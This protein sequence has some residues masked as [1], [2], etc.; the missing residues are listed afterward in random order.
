M[1]LVKTVNVFDLGSPSNPF[2]LLLVSMC[3]QFVP[4]LEHS[5]LNERKQ[6]VQIEYASRRTFLS[7][8]SNFIHEFDVLFENHSVYVLSSKTFFGEPY[9]VGETSTLTIPLSTI[10]PPHKPERC[11]NIPDNLILA[12]YSNFF[13]LT[14]L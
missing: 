11:L 5:N 12:Y 7:L 2:T 13:P 10:F 8:K 9:Y 14:I 3:T 1:Y 6:H 4:S